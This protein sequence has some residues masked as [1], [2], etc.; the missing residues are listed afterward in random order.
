[1]SVQDITSRSSQS[2]QPFQALHSKKSQRTQKSW[3][4]GEHGGLPFRMA[5]V[6]KEKL[7]QLLRVN[8]S[9]PEQVN[10]G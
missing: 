1:M 2:Q 10:M 3:G 8:M 7:L 9:L 5:A 4:G 6:P